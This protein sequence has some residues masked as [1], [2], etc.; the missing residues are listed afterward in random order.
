MSS[1]S[2][3]CVPSISQSKTF[4]VHAKY[5]NLKAVGSGSYGVV[6]SAED[7]ETGKKVA[8]KKVGN[9]FSDL[10]DAKR[11]L[12]ELKLLRHLDGHENVLRIT[13]VMIQPNRLDFDDL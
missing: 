13:D 11:I 6:C 1:P 3:A 9:T 5:A 12:R 4:R 7:T 8:I 2:H 10:I